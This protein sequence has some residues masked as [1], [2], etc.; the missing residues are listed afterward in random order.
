MIKKTC[1]VLGAMCL[2][3]LLSAQSGIIKT[4]TANAPSGRILTME[5][6]ILSRELAPA[7]LYCSWKDAET[8]LMLKDGK[9]QVMNVADGS[10]SEYKGASQTF[11]VAYTE[12]QSLYLRT[13]DGKVTPIAESENS[14][15]TYGQFV[16]R[17]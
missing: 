1:L 15:I 11:P 16:R 14:Q 5:E 6:T 3:L 9:W 17:N 12:G 2:G 8:I 4:R 13:E 10:L 7:N